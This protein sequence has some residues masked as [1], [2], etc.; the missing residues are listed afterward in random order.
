MKA[1]TYP[2]FSYHALCGA[3]LEYDRRQMRRDD[4]NPHA[5]RLYRLRAKDVADDVSRGADPRLAILAAFSGN[6]LRAALRPFGW[7]ATTDE[8]RGKAITYQPVTGSEPWP[9]SIA[10][11]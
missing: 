10:P 2:A 8:V 3:L 6:V 7:T 1:K 5:L 4:W 9:D 11:F